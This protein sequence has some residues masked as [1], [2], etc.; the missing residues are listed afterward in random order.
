[1]AKIDDAIGMMYYIAD[2]LK[3]LRE[4]YSTGDCNNCS[5]KE[6]GYKP[7]PGQIVRYN[8]PFYKKEGISEEKSISNNA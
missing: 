7:K 8:C 4:I 6:C 3:V 2:N 5:N 1:M